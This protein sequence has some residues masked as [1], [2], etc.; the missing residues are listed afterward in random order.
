MNPSASRSAPESLV[1]HHGDAHSAEDSRSGISTVVEP[2]DSGFERARSRRPDDEGVD[3]FR[4]G[5]EGEKPDPFEARMGPNDS[6]NPKSWSKV[7]RWY[8]TALS[9]LLLLNAYVPD[10]SSHVV[11]LRL[12]TD[13]VLE[14]LPRPRL[15]E[16][17]LCLKRSS[18]S[19]GK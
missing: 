14:R 19:A 9:A 12:L 17:S 7:Y 2:T 1:S 16:S 11:E 3:V 10:V 15:S 8:V 6:D 18:G 13:Y 4:D 5:P